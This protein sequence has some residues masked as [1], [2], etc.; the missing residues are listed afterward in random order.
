MRASA[1]NEKTLL[2]LFWRVGPGQGPGWSLR[3]L[4]APQMGREGQAWP[5]CKGWA[6]VQMT[7]DRAGT[8]CFL[9]FHQPIKAHSAERT[10][11]A[12]VTHSSQQPGGQALGPRFT[13]EETKAQRTEVTSLR[14]HRRGGKARIY[15]QVQLHGCGPAAPVPCSSLEVR[16]L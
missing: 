7:E 14:S 13:D 12:R 1:H 10:S 4:A 8:F 9:R 5:P 6:Q 16:P 2:P 11:V 3:A 15:T